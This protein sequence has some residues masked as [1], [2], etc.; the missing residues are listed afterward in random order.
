MLSTSIS[1]GVVYLNII[2]FVIYIDMSFNVTFV[3]EATSPIFSYMHTN[4]CCCFHQRG[5]TNTLFTLT[6]ALIAFALSYSSSLSP[7]CNYFTYVL[8]FFRY[9][10]TL[11]CS[12]T[13]VITTCMIKCVE[14]GFVRIM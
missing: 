2:S 13:F 3:N 14:N 6:I 11:S 9:H 4:Y 8:H 5:L 12:I 10:F 1:S 7:H